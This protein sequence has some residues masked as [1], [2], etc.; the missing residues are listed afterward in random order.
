MTREQIYTE[1][2]KEL[3]IWEPAFAPLVKDLAKTE[4]RRTRI[5]KAWSATAPSG[6]KPSFLDPH[7]QLLVQLDR[8]IL[9]YRRQ[10]GLTPEALRKLRGAAAEPVPQEP[11][12][13]RLDAILARVSSYDDEVRPSPVSESDTLGDE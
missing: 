8:V 5:E 2:L 13:E 6:G 3:G 11:I 10:V 12:A 1:Q 9:E 7:Y 4:R